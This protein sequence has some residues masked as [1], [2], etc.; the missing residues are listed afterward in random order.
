M[1]SALVLALL[2]AS[3][4]FHF[5]FKTGPA[6]K[7]VASNVEGSLTVRPSAA[8]EVK[9]DGVT[10]GGWVVQAVEKDGAIEITACCGKCEERHRDDHDCKGDAQISIQAPAASKLR[11]TVVTAK[12]DVEGITGA[13]ELETVS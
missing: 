6:P 5:Q 9:V 10:H 8:G 4:E 1:T 7:I 13:Q 3:P 2:A 12:L 11:A